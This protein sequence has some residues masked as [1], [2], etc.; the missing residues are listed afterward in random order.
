MELTLKQSTTRIGNAFTRLVELSAQRS[1]FLVPLPPVGGKFVGR[2]MIR[3]PMPCDH[4]GWFKATGQV[5]C[6]DD[7][8]CAVK[9]GFA[10]GNENIVKPHQRRFLIDAGRNG[11]ISGLLVQAT[12]MDVQLVV[13]L[14]WRLLETHERVIHWDDPRLVLLGPTNEAIEFEQLREVS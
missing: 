9:S 4:I 6:W 11:A 3:Q 8:S 5:I 10:I 7:K 13:W 12:H 1:I 14:P 2:E